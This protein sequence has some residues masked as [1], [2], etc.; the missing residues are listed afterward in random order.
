MVMPP[1]GGT[2][3]DRAVCLA[4]EIYNWSAS[5]FSDCKGNDY[6]YNYSGVV[7]GYWTLTSSY[8]NNITYDVIGIY[9]Y[10]GSASIFSSNRH[11]GVNPAPFS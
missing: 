5:D 3:K 11:N 10:D 7:N 2:T 1:V 4:K 6:L 9:C 8:F